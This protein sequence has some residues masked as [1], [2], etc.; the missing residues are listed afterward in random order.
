MQ[1]K[2]LQT[3]PENKLFRPPQASLLRFCWLRWWKN[4]TSHPHK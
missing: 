1:S 4:E 3:E 2:L